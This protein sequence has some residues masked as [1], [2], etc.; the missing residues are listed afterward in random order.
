MLQ[1][2][3]KEMLQNAVCFDLDAKGKITT[4]CSKFGGTPDLPR[5]FVWPRFEGTWFDGSKKEFPLAFLAQIS[6][7]EVHPFDREGKL[8]SSGMLYFF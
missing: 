1:D 6:C 8:P 5:D 7:K 2:K 3:L 4:G